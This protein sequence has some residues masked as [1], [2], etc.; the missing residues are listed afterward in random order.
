MM[1]KILQLKTSVFDAQEN[2]GVSSQ[3]GDAL[4]SRLQQDDTQRVLLTRDFSKAPV[5]YFDNAWLQALSTPP[6]ERSQEQAEKVAYSDALI[7]EIQNADTIVIGVPMY[8]FAIPAAL[9]SWTDHIARAGVTF[10]Y[11]DTGPIGLLVDK[12][13]YVVLSTG[14]QHQEGVT[15]FLRP[16]LRTYFGFLGMTDLEFIV[17][18]GLNMGEASRKEG[19]RKAS[20][21]IQ[22][23]NLSSPIGVAV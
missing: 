6:S 20:V 7:A 4:V 14:G 22:N 23:L 18:D 10:R 12:K 11:T 1:S 3:L 5:P 8:N 17:A 9:K 19:L 13:V 16:Y 21:Q 15:D 2:Q